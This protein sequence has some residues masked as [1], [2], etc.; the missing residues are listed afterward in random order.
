MKLSFPVAFFAAIAVLISPLTANAQ[1][2]SGTVFEFSEQFLEAAEAIDGA[3]VV[4]GNFA[5]AD[6]L[7]TGAGS[8]ENVTQTVDFPLSEFNFPWG[9]LTNTDGSVYQQGYVVSVQFAEAPEET[10]LVVGALG[11]D[12][13]LT[14]NAS[15][16]I[17]IGVCLVSPTPANEFQGLTY[18]IFDGDTLL[19]TLSIDTRTDDTGML[20]SDSEEGFIVP[21]GAKITRVEI[22]AGIEP[23]N[24]LP[25]GLV[26]NVKFLF[27]DE[28]DAEP[29]V[30]QPTCQDQLASIAADI[31]ALAA[32]SGTMAQDAAL[33]LPV[34]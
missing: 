7:F 17:P 31:D 4:S 25:T 10:V 22:I 27:A 2:G 5:E 30:E 28:F 6:G 23:V 21:R 26:N 24:S 3:S 12:Q 9:V 34:T 15:L 32:T 8:A 33:K 20:V 16:G 14:P 19:E 18:N 11:A 29:P 1:T 13:T